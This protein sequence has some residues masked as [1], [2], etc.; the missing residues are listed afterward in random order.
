MRVPGPIFPAFALIAAAAML[1]AAGP[2]RAQPIEAN[3]DLGGYVPAP[4]A[5]APAPVSYDAPESRSSLDG[6][7]P[8]HGSGLPYFAGLRGSFAFRNSAGPYTRTTP[9]NRV[10]ANY[11]VGGGGSLYYG[12]RLPFGLRAELEG[13]YRYQPLRNLTINGAAKAGAH[14]KA[15]MAAPMINLLWELPVT[16]AFPIQPF[17]GMGAGAAYTLTDITDGTNTYLKNDGWN[18]AYSFMAGAN[19]PLSQ[20]SRFTAMYRWMRVNDVKY[21]CGT[22]GILGSCYKTN[23]TSQGID[24]GLE[25][26]L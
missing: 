25:M 18:L 24:L 21:G 23:L 7:T 9:V 13:L 17:V 14:G 10:K 2:A 16:D 6:D 15:E 4:S 26:D 22:G 11:D 3:P 1:P 19:V 20:S 8:A 12:I 5:P